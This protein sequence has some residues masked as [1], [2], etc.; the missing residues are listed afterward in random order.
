MMDKKPWEPSAKLKMNLKKSAISTA[1][2][3]EAIIECYSYLIG[4]EELV[5]SVFKH[6]YKKAGISSENPSKIDLVKLMNQLD[7]VVVSFRTSSCIHKSKL[8]L[9]SFIG[10]CRVQIPPETVPINTEN[11]I[12]TSRDVALRMARQMGFS[13][14]NVNKIVTT[15]SELTRNVVQYTPGGI[16]KIGPLENNGSGIEIM[17]EDRGQG[18]QNLDRIMAGKF[19]SKSGLGMGIVGCKRLMDSLNIETG[20]NG[21]RIKAVKYSAGI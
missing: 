16:I 21:T 14:V 7:R 11:D 3:H 6:Q 8:H 4:D 10:L 13:S 19:M 15:V 1:E 9:K 18:I 17:V 12:A 5:D 20:E 2:L